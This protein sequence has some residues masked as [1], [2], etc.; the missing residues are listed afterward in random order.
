[1]ELLVRADMLAEQ[2]DVT[3]A[4]IHQTIEGN[5]MPVVQLTEDGYVVEAEVAQRIRM[6]YRN[7]ASYEVAEPRRI[8]MGQR[9]WTA[10]DQTD[11]D[12]GHRQFVRE[13][14]SGW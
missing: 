8:P 6:I 14:S 11:A 13:H 1:M 3:V 2:L 4:Q 7:A 10:G 9:D 5:R 12:R